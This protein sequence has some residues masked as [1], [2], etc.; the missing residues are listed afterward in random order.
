M[1][2]EKSAAATAAE[3]MIPVDDVHKVDHSR[4]RLLTAATAGIGA[5]GVVFA[6]VPFIASWEPSVRAKALG[7]PGPSMPR[8]SRTA[9]CSRSSGAASRCSSCAGARRSS[10]DRQ[11]QR[12]ARGSELG[13]LAAAANTSRI[14]ARRA[15]AI[16][17]TGWV[18]PFAPT[19]AAPRSAHSSPIT[20]SGGGHRSRAEL[21]GRI[22]L[23]VPWLEVR[24]IGRVF[25]SM[26]APKN[27]TVP[28]VRVLGRCAHRDRRRRSSQIQLNVTRLSD[29]RST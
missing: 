15:R 11:S 26:P 21:A 27:L 13:R 17:S 22:L 7:A 4:R 14:P 16:P 5:V 8:S 28:S 20:L 6:A 10:R 2:D 12:L 24:Y 1:S 3:A 19:W 29:G 9:R 23:P 18:W 25:K